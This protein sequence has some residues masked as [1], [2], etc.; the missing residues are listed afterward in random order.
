MSQN[1]E[2]GEHSSSFF[3]I[4]TLLF[5]A[6]LLLLSLFYFRHTAQ[7]IA[8]V[9]SFL[10]SGFPVLKESC[11]NLLHGEIFDEN[12]LMTIAAIGAFLI[13]EYPEA[14]AVMLL[15]Q[16]GEYLQDRAVDASRDTIHSLLAMRPDYANLLSGERVTADSVPVGTLIVVRPGERIPLDGIIREGSAYV[17]VSPLT[18]ESLPQSWSVG[19]TALAGCINCDGVLTIEVTKTFQNS[20]ISRIMKLVEDAQANKAEPE[21]F[22][23]RFAKIYTPVV[24]LLALL[25]AVFPPLLALGTWQQWIHKALSFLVISC[26]CA[27]VLSIPL[28]FF[29]GIGAASH[30][31]ILCK[32][33]NYLELMSKATAILFDKTGTL[34]EGN[35]SLAKLVPAE[36]VSAE[37]LLQVAAYGESQS[38]HPLAKAICHAYGKEIDYARLTD[39]KEKSGYGI[40]AQWDYHK[41]LVGKKELL[42]PIAIPCVQDAQTAVYVAMDGQYLGHIIFTDT[43]KPSSKK[44]ISML[45]GAGLQRLAILSGDRQ[46]IVQQAASEM[47]IPQAFGNLLPEDKVEIMRNWQK[48]NTTIYVG[49][50]IND[51]PVLTAADVGIAMGGLGSEAAI[52][53]APVVIL[54]EEPLKIFEAI[55]IGK[56]TVKIARENIIFSISMKGLILLLSIAFNFGLWIAVFADVGVCLLAILNSLRVRSGIQSIE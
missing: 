3:S 50:G 10:L 15:Y 9:I 23:T 2:H 55:A 40:Q 30:C 43:I 41:I 36:N 52:E 34:T 27:L 47:G 32:G 29:S 45:K 53:A 33:G 14:A 39:I 49:D 26:P 37:Y 48:D 4:I 42:F 19:Q 35:F 21:K 11:I 54:S 51:V 17:D 1:S 38:T 44:A 6:A 20:G 13:G 5:S 18:G 22:I 16:I 7:L 25:I 12:L 28:T 31:G 8:C 56:K 24:C 46:T